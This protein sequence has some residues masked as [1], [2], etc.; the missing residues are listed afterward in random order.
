[1]HAELKQFESLGSL[2]CLRALRTC[3]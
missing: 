3:L 2:A 1:M